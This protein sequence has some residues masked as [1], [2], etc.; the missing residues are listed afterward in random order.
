MS[1]YCNRLNKEINT[2]IIEIDKSK[3]CLNITFAFK[4]PLKDYNYNYK[5]NC[6]YH[7]SKIIQTFFTSDTEIWHFLFIFSN[8]QL[9]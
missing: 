9:F 1:N 3:S 2:K 7:L 8:D 6:P 4:K 5:T